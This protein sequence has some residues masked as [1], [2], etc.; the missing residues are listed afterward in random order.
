MIPIDRLEPGTATHANVQEQIA[1]PGCRE[2]I[3]AALHDTGYTITPPKP[4]ITSFRVV[5]HKVDIDHLKIM[6]RKS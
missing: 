6:V 3:I 4:K 2:T 5:D 1:C